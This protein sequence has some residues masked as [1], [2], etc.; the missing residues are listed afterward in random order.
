MPFACSI[1]EAESTRICAACTKDACEN[2][3]CE[4]CQGCSDC[5]KCGITLVTPEHQSGRADRP[6]PP[7]ESWS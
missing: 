7:S 2:H 6:T 1:C 4:K 5:C 3:L